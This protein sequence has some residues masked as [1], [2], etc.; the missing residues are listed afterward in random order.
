MKLTS[1]FQMFGLVVP[2]MLYYNFRIKKCIIIIIVIF[3][4][5]GE[6]C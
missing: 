6:L 5:Y 3:Q 4:L 1:Y 2:V